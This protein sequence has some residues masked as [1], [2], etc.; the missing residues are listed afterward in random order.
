M[1]KQELLK[2]LKVK[3]GLIEETLLTTEWNKENIKSMYDLGDMIK[4]ID[5][6]IK[7]I[8]L[9]EF[10]SKVDELVEYYN[11]LEELKEYKKERNEENGE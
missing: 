1:K 3:K 8:K 6:T 4:E 5:I 9:I 10:E 7:N 2:H 11:T